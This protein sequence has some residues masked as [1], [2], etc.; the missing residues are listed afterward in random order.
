M[1]ITI[2][3]NGA[4]GSALAELSRRRWHDV[5]LWGRHPKKGEATDLKDALDQSEIVLLAIPSHAMRQICQQAKPY[6]SPHTLLVSMAKGIEQ[7]TDL[8]MSEVIIDSTSKNKVAVISGPGFAEEVK[9]GLPCAVAC[10]ATEEKWAKEIQ[11]A[12]NGEDFRVYT[13]ADVVGVEL[14]GALK[15]VM[16]IAAGICAGMGLGESAIATLIT[17]GTIE[18]SRIGT[19]L[20]GHP[21]TFFGL[22]GIGDLI[23]TCSSTQSRNHQVGKKL[24]QGLALSDIL[25]SLHGTAEGVKTAHSVHQ[26]L[27]KK[28]LE[29]PILQEVYS[30][31]YQQK[32]V[33]EALKTLMGR[34]PKRE[35]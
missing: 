32:P 31:L 20:G 28:N 30:V 6:I 13:S 2:L 22:S 26:I 14:G 19:A 16:A 27:Q 9:A 17:R 25:A 3:G 5:K 10:A 35:F 34:E 1:K 18:L 33:R 24:A 11:A 21:Q 12:F 4:W 7:D 23:L 29:A 8:R 15:N